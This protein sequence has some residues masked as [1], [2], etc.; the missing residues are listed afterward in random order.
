MPSLL[1]SGSVTDLTPLVFF[2]SSR[3]SCSRGSVPSFSAFLRWS[4]A[5]EEIWSSCLFSCGWTCACA[6]SPG[7][8]CPAPRAAVLLLLGLLVGLV[9]VVLLAR[10]DLVDLLLI[11][12]RRLLRQVDADQQRAV[13]A[14]A[15]AGG[16][17]VVGPA[18]VGA[19]RHRAVV[20]LAEVEVERRERQHDEDDQRDEPPPGSG[21][22]RRSRPSGPSRAA[23]RRGLRCGSGIGSLSIRVADDR[24]DRR[25]QRDRAAQT[26][27]TTTSADV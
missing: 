15:E 9:L 18:R 5:F 11:R 6:W 7:G 1:T 21:G 3:R 19:L 17:A 13:G 8:A 26:A 12:L 4:D 24:Q 23:G 22:S 10:V 16:Q 25:Q 2:R 27:T 14:R 20:L